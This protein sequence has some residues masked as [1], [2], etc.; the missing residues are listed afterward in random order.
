MY[1]T[2]KSY[3]HNQ[4][5]AQLQGILGSVPITVWY[6]TEAKCMSVQSGVLDGT[7]MLAR[8]DQRW[9]QEYEALVRHLDIWCTSSKYVPLDEEEVSAWTGL[10]NAFEILWDGRA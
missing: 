8:P 6:G 4:D 5:I 2:F 10:K 3:Y 7:T 1:T 9:P